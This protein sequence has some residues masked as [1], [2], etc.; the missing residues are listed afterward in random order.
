MNWNELD[1][2]TRSLTDVE[3]DAVVSSVQ[4][5][6]R[7]RAET[8][9]EFDQMNKATCGV[10]SRFLGNEIR[11][12]EATRYERRLEDLMLQGYGYDASKALCTA[13]GLSIMDRW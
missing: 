9:A 2:F 10:Y 3:F 4:N 11:R 1:N 6:R 13:E 5:V 12:R 8:R 7:V